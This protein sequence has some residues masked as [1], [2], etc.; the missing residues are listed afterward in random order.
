MQ[1]T[2]KDINETKVKITVVADSDD[3]L[4][5]KNHVVSHMAPKVKL[6][7]F[8][9][10]K[11]P[12]ELAEK[13]IDQNQLQSE[14]LDTV[15]RQ[16]FS[17]AVAQEKVRVIAAPNVEL[18]KFVP[19][20]LIE[21]SAEVE[22]IGKIK[23][24]DYKNV[25]LSKKEVKVSKKDVDEVLNRLQL[26]MATFSIAER[27]SK[28]GDRVWIDFKGTDDKGK[29]VNG[30]EGK[31]YPLS[32]GSNTFIPGFEGNIVGLK[33]DDKKTFTLDFPKDY[34]VKALQSKK[35]TFDITV[36][37]VEDTKLDKID[38]NF[39]KKAG[40]FKDLIALRAD[41]KK[42]VEA[43]RAN[44]ADREYEE[45]IV[46]AIAAKTKFNLP[47]TL[48]NE[49]MDTLDKEFRQNLTYRGQTFQE[50]LDSKEM[51]DDEYRET[52]LKPVAVDRLKAGIVLNEISDKEG[53]KV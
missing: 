36:K 8:R 51:K 21:F 15:I 31:D 4:P 12:L 17:Q 24:A 14:V 19:F 10:G 29:P 3:I 22:V 40:P 34:Q 44:Q 9:E 25:K 50:Y 18:T 53:I 47:E 20:T 35:V 11:V 46:K 27:A 5:I 41:I 48:I 32:L 38:D 23:L 49:Q 7:G 16:L 43:E 6:A 1:V 52:E 33:K 13:H 37:K 2:I 39:A 42:Q 28:T 26:N 30:A 45:N